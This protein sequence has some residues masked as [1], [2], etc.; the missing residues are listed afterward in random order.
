MTYWLVL[1]GWLAWPILLAAG[2]TLCLLVPLAL[3]RLHLLLRSSREPE[4]WG[5]W[6]GP[7]PRVTVQLPV[8]NE[9]KVVERLIDAVA[10]L[11]YPRELLEVQ[12]LDDSTDETVE[13][14]GARVRAWQRRGRRIRHLRRNNRAGYKAGALAAGLEL[15][16]GEFILILD[17]DFVPDPTLIHELLGPFQDPEVG[18]VQARWD[19][20]N[21]TASLLTRCQALLLDAHFY[22]EH[23]GRSASGCFLNFNGT[24]GIWRRRALDDAGGWSADT[25]TEDL[26]VSY[27]AQ[28]AGWRFV[29]RPE[30]GVS[31]ELPDSARALEVQ[32]KRWSQG[33]MQTARK[34]LPTLLSGKWSAGV[35]GEAIAHLL[36]HLAHPLT[37]LLGIL[38][39]PSALARRSLGFE[40]LLYLDIL[41]FATATLSFLIFYSAAGR[42]RHRPWGSIL[43]TALATLPLGIGL[44]A[45]VSRAV[46][47]G[48]RRDLQDP[49]H[50]TPK[51]GEGRRASGSPSTA[52]DLI[53][54]AGLTGWTVMSAIVALQQGLLTTLPFL[55]LFGAGYGWLLFAEVL[56]AQ[57]WTRSARTSS[58]STIDRRCSPTPSRIRGSSVM[59]GNG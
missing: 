49:F 1:P 34:I 17:A 29:F 10:R 27:R 28:M 57:G 54:K 5:P 36:G 9:P 2:G 23:G 56:E 35:K 25:L 44:G 42:K 16:E 13:R 40:R 47:R 45:T 15:A 24:A 21:E 55:L 48:A 20:L 59:S 22:F 6:V 11:D 33:G 51:R 32:Q 31:A 4:E 43:P 30:I 18:M 14:A 39:V 8:F 58:S 26:D 52:G 12:V 38:L 3:H 41:V 19:H 50:R 53:A 46:L 37:L 7:L